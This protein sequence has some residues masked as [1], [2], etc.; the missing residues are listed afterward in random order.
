MKFIL[1]VNFMEGNW[2]LTKSQVEAIWRELPAESVL[3]I[4]IGNE[5]RAWTVAFP[6]GFWC[7]GG[8]TRTR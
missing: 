5:V 6:L 4:E 8:L 3:G 1:G 2:E 7:L